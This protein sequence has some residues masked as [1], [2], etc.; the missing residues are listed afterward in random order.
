MSHF[1]CLSFY[2][3]E[4]LFRP[5]ALWLFPNGYILTHQMK[6]PGILNGFECTWTCPGM[7]SERSP[8][9]TLWDWL[10]VITDPHR[11]IVLLTEDFLS[12]CCLASSFAFSG[13]ILAL[14]FRGGATIP[15]VA[16]SEGTRKPAM[17][18]N[19]HNCSF[20]ASNLST[21]SPSCLSSS[22]LPF[23]NVPDSNSLLRFCKSPI[24]V[25]ARC[26]ISA[27]LREAPGS[28]PGSN[29]ARAVNRF[30]NLSRLSRSQTRHLL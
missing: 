28:Y 15:S 30:F 26:N 19:P 17:R 2:L 18:N 13:L 8:T 25:A 23:F 1:K 6:Y 12:C 9:D 21:R 29:L 4:K 20:L 24:D 3:D 10:T 27:L 7:A 5:S 16:G 22:Q 14:H 11:W